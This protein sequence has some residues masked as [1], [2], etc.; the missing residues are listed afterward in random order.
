[1]T[2]L[3]AATTAE[4]TENNLVA[5]PEDEWTA[6]Q[7][8]LDTFQ[9][10][11]EDLQNEVEVQA[12]NTRGAHARISKLSERV[13]DVEDH[14]SASKQGQAATDA[15]ARERQDA[16]ETWTPLETVVSLP[17]DVAER[18]LHPTQKRARFIMKDLTDYGTKVRAGIRIDA[19]DMRRVLT[20]AAE[21]GQTIHRS[22]TKRVMDLLDDLG[23]EDVKIRT[24]RGRTFMIVSNELVDRLQDQQEHRTRNSGWY[25]DEAARV[26]QVA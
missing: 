12:S 4:L 10:G 5:V 11:L 6:T 2:T 20:A 7:E 16:P 21:P 3:T 22:Q 17:E 13:D 23:R 26:L 15:G 24:K 9:N 19:T 8:R 25:G 1:M 14:S 18:E